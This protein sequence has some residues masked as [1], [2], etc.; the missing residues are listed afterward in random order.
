MTSG[1]KVKAAT[2]DWKLWTAGASL[3][4]MVMAAS[5]VFA[6]ENVTISHG[7]NFFGDL[8]YPA[9]YQQLNYVN[10]AAPKGGEIAIWGM[11]TFDSFNPYTRKGRAGGS[12]S[13]GHEDI[14]TTF[15]DDPTAS[16]CFLCETM[17]YPED[18]S[19]VIF[20]LRDDVT[21]PD[22]KGWSA[23]DLKFTFDLFM[24]QGLPSFRAAFG[25][26]ISDVEILDT[27]RIKF[28]FNADS[29]GRDRIGLAGIFPAFSKA[30]FEE[31]GARLD[32]SS[33]VPIMGTGIYELD[34]YEINQ[35]VVYKRRDD[36]WAE[37]LP[38]SVGRYNFDQI[39]I[40]YFADSSA[41]F[42]GFKAGEYTFR[43]ENSSKSWATS[44]NFP[45]LSD[46][47]VIKTELH[48][49]NLAQAQ[50]YVFNLR[51]EKFQDK[52][53]REAIG[54]MFNFEWSNE[55]LF[56]GLYER[57]NG[58]W[59]NS[60]M[61]AL[62]TPSD[63]E[64]ALLKPLVDEGLLDASILTD[65]AILPPVSGARQLDRGNL[66]KASA[67]LDEAG[68]VVGDDGMR[69]KDG[70]VLSVEILDS[71]PAFDRIH[72]PFIENL[73]RLGVEAVLNRVDPAQE[74]DRTRSYDFDLTTHVM[75]QAL[76]PSTGLEQWF[77]SE[78]R[79]ESSRNLMGLNS[80][81][82]DRLIENVVGATT[83]EEMRVGVRALDRVLRA[84]VFWVPQWFKDVHTVAFYD[85]YGYPDP[86]PDYARGELDFW[87]FEADKNAELVSAGVL[88]R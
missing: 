78:A 41:A 14:L 53:V 33:L 28:S 88:A 11:G 8:K 67:L 49:G 39:R 61:E 75:T 76:E 58:F 64:M 47:H 38:V 71:S 62:G 50:G 72:N 37:D 57:V 22:G 85:Q 60:D 59:G 73:K 55:S 10:A 79:N 20:N 66:R 42:E 35:Q 52:R 70:E 2:L 4:G 18:L 74:T 29:P 43:S 69:R 86:L 23:E 25:A 16:Y 81:A 12:P 19:W 44:Y 46:G 80:P 26:F 56:F 77:G 51:R 27:H 36:Y 68:W 17:E 1:A 13:I 5:S 82:V 24:E 45:A 65:E 6:D 63:A 9:D 34:S 3:V 48:N 31:T 21:F 40:E 83:K 30:W 87:W 84:E 15:A 54:M 7:Y 32:E